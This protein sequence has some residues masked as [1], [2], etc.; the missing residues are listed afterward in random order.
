MTETERSLAYFLRY[1][2]WILEYLNI[3]QPP[4]TLTDDERVRLAGQYLS[5]VSE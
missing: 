2:E 3:T 1:Q 4:E 5:S